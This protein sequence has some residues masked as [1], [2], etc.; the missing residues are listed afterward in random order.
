MVLLFLFLKLNQFS[1][2][3]DLKIFLQNDFF[4]ATKIIFFDD[5]D[6]LIVSDQS[7]VVVLA[8]FLNLRQCLSHEEECLLAIKLLSFIDECEQEKVIALCSVVHL[9]IHLIIQM[10]III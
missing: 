3:H 5:I 10:L 9:K 6:V 4:V 1:E 8:E 7:F 2:V